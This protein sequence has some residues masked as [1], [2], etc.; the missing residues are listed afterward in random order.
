MRQLY[1]LTHNNQVREL[2]FTKAT[3]QW[4]EKTGLLVAIIP[5]EG[6]VSDT[7]VAVSIKPTWY[8]WGPHTQDVKSVKFL[9]SGPSS[10]AAVNQVR[11]QRANS[12]STIDPYRIDILS[13]NAS[14]STTSGMSF[15]IDPNSGNKIISETFTLG[16]PN[17][18][19]I[20]TLFS[21]QLA[22]QAVIVISCD[23]PRS[24]STCGKDSTT[25]PAPQPVWIDGDGFPKKISPDSYPTS[26]NPTPTDFSSKPDCK[27]LAQT[28]RDAQSARNAALNNYRAAGLSLFGC[29]TVILCPSI[30][31]WLASAEEGY[32]L[33][34]D[35]L[36][37]AEVAY[38]DAKC[39][40]K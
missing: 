32:N 4:E 22:A 21:T 33:A 7:V 6:G 18:A 29:I 26:N 1:A 10:S 12:S 36:S 24:S 3:Q 28:L 16:A 34:N 25:P 35:Q 39:D 19:Q 5:F 37:R 11:I 20:N 17:T 40:K 14:G 23:D 13:Y 38:M 9:K 31:T 15:T 27:A 8:F 2:D 30:V